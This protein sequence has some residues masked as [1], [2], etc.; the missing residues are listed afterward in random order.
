MGVP[1]F[2]L[3]S[4]SVFLDMSPLMVIQML[5][6][7]FCCLV[8]SLL[9]M[10]FP[11]YSPAIILFPDFFSGFYIHWPYLCGH[12][13]CHASRLRFLSCLFVSVL[14]DQWYTSVGMLLNGGVLT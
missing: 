3:Y 10:P 1:D 7:C 9:G 14:Q 11:V 5:T 4:A 6:D 13:L 8:L 2:L 12:D